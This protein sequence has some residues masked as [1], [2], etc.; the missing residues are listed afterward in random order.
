MMHGV[1]VTSEQVRPFDSIQI[2]KPLLFGAT[3][4]LVLAG[5]IVFVVRPSTVPEPAARGDEPPAETA[6]PEPAE[7]APPPT[8]TP[9]PSAATPAA[10]RPAAPPKPVGA[11]LV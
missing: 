4:M 2:M 7:P 1:Y 9:R 3:A 11:T 6:P 10:P 5:V 8:T